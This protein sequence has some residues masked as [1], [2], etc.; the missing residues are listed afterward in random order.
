MA[1]ATHLDLGLEGVAQLLEL[2]IVV[3]LVWHVSG[4]GHGD[5]G[6]G[7]ALVV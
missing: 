1:T 5:G 2:G 7:G 3:A 6:G 4:V